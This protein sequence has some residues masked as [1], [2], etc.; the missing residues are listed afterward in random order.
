MKRAFAGLKSIIRGY[1]A[2]HVSLHAAGLTYC[3][4]LAIVPVL[5]ML[6]LVARTFR[7]DEFVKEQIN[8]RIDAMITH[9]EAGQEDDLANVAVISDEQR[10]QKKELAHEFGLRARALSEQIFARIEN[11]DLNTLG[12]IGLLMLLWT[13][14]SSIGMV[15][16]SFNEIWGAGKPRP[17]LRRFGLYLLVALVVPVL[18][19][20][21]MSVPILGVIKKIVVRTVGVANQAKWLSDG[22]IMFLDSPFLRY[23]LVFI[24]TAFNFAFLYWVMPNCRVR[25][26]HAFLGGMVT[27]VLLG[28][29]IKVCAILQV[30]IANSSAL[31]GSL[32]LLPIVL[33]WMYMSWQIILLGAVTVHTMENRSPPGNSPS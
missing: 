18:M 4:L 28:F 20:L 12:W 15:E 9:I 22:L 16:V 29:W 19:A 25:F 24:A 11:F 5:C 6:L 26:K 33:A 13:V 1:L 7:A 2:N 14:Y 21:A 31:Y 32:A 10:A 8:G 23:V 17:L 3:S 27:A 30:G